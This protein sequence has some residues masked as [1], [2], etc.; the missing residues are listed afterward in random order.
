MA[1]T[2]TDLIPRD[3]ADQAISAAEQESVVLALG[4]VI[5]MSAGTESVPVVSVAPVVDFVTPAYGGRKPMTTV[6][7]TSEQLI[8]VEIAATLAIPDAF[9]DDA[10]FPVWESVRSELAKAIAKKLDQAIIFGT[11][12]PAEFPTGGIAG[13]AGAAQSGATAEEAIDLALAAVEAQGVRPSG[14]AAGLSIL[15]ALRQS[16]LAAGMGPVTQQ[17]AGQLFGLPV[18]TT[19]HWLP[20]AGDALVG[21]FAGALVI[22]IREDVTYELSQEGVLVDGT[23]AIV[24]T[25]FQDDM[26]LMRVRL[27]VA[28]AIA[29]PVGAGGAAVIPFEFADWTATAAAGTRSA[30]K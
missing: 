21:D 5:R 4:N 30:K 12:A 18:E 1:T 10:G 7:W 11:D 22:G 3:I 23:G 15:S 14:I 20:A 27:R 24:V 19:I 8:P 9:I 29:Q 13:L 25:A 6:E 2:Y 16:Q 17:A 26:T 28:C